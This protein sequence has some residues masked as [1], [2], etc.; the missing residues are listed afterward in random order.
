MM[1]KR[2]DIT[3]K[4]PKTDEEK[5]YRITDLAQ[6]DDDLHRRCATK[7]QSKLAECKKEQ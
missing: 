4:T 2:G 7:V 6:L 5:D 1:E 3:N